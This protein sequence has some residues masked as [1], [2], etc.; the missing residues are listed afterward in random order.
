MPENIRVEGDSFSMH[1]DAILVLRGISKRYGKN[2]AVDDFTLEVQRGEF[3]TILGESGAGK[4]TLLK[5]IAGMICPDSG[6]IILLGDDITN[7][8]SHKRPFAMVFQS[9]ALF[10]HMSVREN[11]AFPLRRMRR[12]GR[13]QIYE[14]VREI[15][16]LLGIQALEHRMP[17]QLSGGQQQRVALGRALLKVLNNQSGVGQAV[18]LMDEPLSSIDKNLRQ[19][20]QAEIKRLQKQLGLTILYVTHEQTEALSMSDRVVLIRSGRILQVERP[21]H[22]YEKPATR[23]VANFFGLSNLLTGRL[24]DSKST[25]IVLPDGTNLC[26]PPVDYLAGESVEILVHPEKLSFTPLNN[27]HVNKIKVQVI[28]CYYLGSQLVFLTRTR[29]GQEFQVRQLNVSTQHLPTI[30]DTATVYWRVED[31]VVVK[32]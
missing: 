4:S 14:K 12:F 17:N 32:S 23:Y 19:A 1:N 6:N 13:Q 31:T 30:G 16:S 2:I 25:N 29:T 24:A 10:P 3:V 9:Y 21:A 11:L 28:D 5:I 27:A 15:C 18:L 7:Q 22:L 20:M 8:P 26:I